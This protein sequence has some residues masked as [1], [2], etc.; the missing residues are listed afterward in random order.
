MEKELEILTHIQENEYITQ[1]EI[2]EKQVCL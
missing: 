1:R 2:A